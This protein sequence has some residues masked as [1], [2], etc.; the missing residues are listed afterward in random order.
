[1]AKKNLNKLKVV[2]A[3]KEKTN[4]WLAEQLGKD[5]AMISKWCTNTT[6]PSL[7]M[8]L[9]IAKVLEVDVRELIRNLD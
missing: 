6:Q 3:D 5:Q 1:M 4:K 9:Q 8:L 7:E 2:L